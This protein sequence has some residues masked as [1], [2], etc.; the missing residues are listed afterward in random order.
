MLSSGGRVIKT[1][2]SDVKF[3]ILDGGFPSVSLA[4]LEEGSSLVHF[5]VSI[6]FSSISKCSS[7]NS[8]RFSILSRMLFS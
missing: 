1:S 3:G 7:I 6:S 5:D 2:P 4:E 8:S